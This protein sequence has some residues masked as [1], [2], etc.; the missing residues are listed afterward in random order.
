M[1]F[2]STIYNNSSQIFYLNVC[3]IL[4]KTFLFLLTFQDDHFFFKLCCINKYSFQSAS[5]VFFIYSSFICDQLRFL[6]S[7]VYPHT[8][9]VDG[10]LQHNPPQLQQQ[11]WSSG[12]A[13][14]QLYFITSVFSSCDSERFIFN[15]SISGEKK[16]PEG[17]SVAVKNAQNNNF[18]KYYNFRQL[19]PKTPIFK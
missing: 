11:E 7:N 2:T 13:Q 17:S 9:N 15:L 14:F 1:F 5:V 8:R 4:L 16:F 19:K 18:Y 6:S 10:D 12:P 3:S